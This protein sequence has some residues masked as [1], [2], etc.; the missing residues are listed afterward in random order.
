[1]SLLINANSVQANAKRLNYYSLNTFSRNFLIFIKLRTVIKEVMYRKIFFSH[2]IIPTYVPW[3]GMCHIHFLGV[4]L[5][6]HRYEKLS[7]LSPSL[8]FLLKGRQLFILKYMCVPKNVEKHNK[9]SQSTDF[10]LR[11][12]LDPNIFFQICRSVLKIKS[13]KRNWRDK[14]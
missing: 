11:L 12:F 9:T 2:A 1:M 5:N 3:H 14:K 7:I 8:L 6:I 10:I 13:K 4:L